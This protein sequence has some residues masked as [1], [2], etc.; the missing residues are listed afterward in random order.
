MIIQSTLQNTH[1]AAKLLI[2]LGVFLFFLSISSI[3]GLFVVSDGLHSMNDISQMT[4]YSNVTILKSIKIVQAISII[5]SFIIPSLL[6]VYFTSEKKFSYLKLNDFRFL[7]GIIVLLLVFAVMPFIN[8]TGEVNSHLALPDFMSSVERWMKSSEDVA[9]KLT[10]AFLQMNGIGDLCA[11]LFIVALLAAVG[12]E[13]FFRGAMQNLFVEWTKKVHLSVWITAILFS[14]LH[15]QFYGFIP[16]MI[17]GVV[18]GYI[19]VWSGSLWLSMLFHFLNN[20]M[21]VVISYLIS[22]KIISE[23]VETV[24]AE[25]E[26]WIY[27]VVSVI[28]SI[29]LLIIIYKD[30]NLKKQSCL[31]QQSSGTCSEVP[32]EKF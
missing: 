17:L 31:L 3:I 28:V 21:A 14:A 10:E 2:L 27:V 24:G 25:K 5:G 23:S 11:N 15:V 29:W 22:N 1:P 32:S 4:D 9:K 16:R 20:G 26:T 8:W 12:E 6:F 13:L 7:S 19:Y 18:L 30:S